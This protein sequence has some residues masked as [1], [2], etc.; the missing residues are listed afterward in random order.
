[1]NTQRMMM[2]TEQPRL[3]IIGRSDNSGLS[4]ELSDFSHGLFDAG[5]ESSEEGKLT[6]IS[7]NDREKLDEKV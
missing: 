5:S 4:M 1:M 6:A 7:V 3:S 2:S